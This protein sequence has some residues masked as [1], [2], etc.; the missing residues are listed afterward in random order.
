[1]LQN[2]VRTLERTSRQTKAEKAQL[3]EVSDKSTHIGVAESQVLLQ[4]V[5]KLQNQLEQNKQELKNIKNSLS[6]AQSDVSMLTTKC[7]DLRQQ[8]N[9]LEHEKDEEIGTSYK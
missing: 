7:S 1:M 6:N 3:Q 5:T 8:K 9:H 4:E 2:K